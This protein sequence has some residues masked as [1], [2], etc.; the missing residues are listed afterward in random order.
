MTK[1]LLI[2]SAFIGL[3]S[4]WDAYAQISGVFT[5]RDGTSASCRTSSGNT[6]QQ[7][8]APKLAATFLVGGFTGVTT[9]LPNGSARITWD[10]GRLSSLPIA[11]HDY[12]YFHECAHAHVPTSDELVANCVGLIDMRAAGR[13]SPSIE[14]QLRVFHAG[15]GNMGPRYGTG[16]DYWTRTLKCAGGGLPAKSPQM[17]STL[18]TTC[19]FASGALAG[20]T[21]DF[22]NQPGV[23]PAVVGSQCTDG[24]GSYGI[25]VPTS[26]S[27]ATV[28]V[29]GNWRGILSGAAGHLTLVFHFGSN[30]EGTVDS[31]SQ[32]AFGIPMQY[33]LKGNNVTLSMPSLGAVYTADVAG[34]R[35]SGTFSQNG[36]LPLT[37]ARQ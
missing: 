10:S 37:L 19:G 20:Q 34:N 27:P 35:M 2:A 8:Y 6:V 28:G 32:G 36:N 30:G 12:I 25:A 9:P 21:I 31:V 33:S 22:G 7:V 14:E 17:D 23:T 26:S 4:S 1:H 15:L 13:S 16:A 29:E 11:A 5:F 24:A 3:A 18:T